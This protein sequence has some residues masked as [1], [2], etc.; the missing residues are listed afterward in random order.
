MADR[1]DR[2]TRG[3]MEWGGNAGRCQEL[4]SAMQAREV[5]RSYQ[6]LV[7]GRVIAGATIE[8]PLGRHPT[9]RTRFAIR[10]DGRQAVTHYRVNARWAYHSLLD[11]RLETGRTHQI[12]VHLAHLGHPVVGDPVYGSGFKAKANTLSEP[13]AAALAALGRQALHAAELGFEHPRTGKELFF[14]SPLPA[15]V[16]GLAA[17]LR[18]GHSRKSRAIGESK[19]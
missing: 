7:W 13:A 4:S 8:A 17:A 10:R 11:V 6:A 1:R 15:D 5:H 3:R 16:A 19:R 18:A 14:S 12:R 2:V 9:D